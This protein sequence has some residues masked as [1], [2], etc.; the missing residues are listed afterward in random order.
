[1]AIWDSLIYRD[2]HAKRIAVP[3]N[4][5]SFKGA[6]PGGYVKEPHVGMH[7]WVCSFDFGFSISIN[8]YAI[9]YVA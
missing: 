4:A 3:Q 8:H 6:Y 9:Q 7:D 1:M 2:L 5:E